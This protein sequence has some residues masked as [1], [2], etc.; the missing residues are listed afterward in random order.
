MIVLRIKFKHDRHK[1]FYNFI[2][3][4]TCLKRP[5]II[6][7]LNKGVEPDHKE[8]PGIEMNRINAFLFVPIHQILLSSWSHYNCRKWF[9]QLKQYISDNDLG[10]YPFCFNNTGF[11]A[12]V[13]PA[14]ALWWR[15]LTNSAGA[16]AR[17]HYDWQAD[18]Q[19]SPLLFL[20]SKLRKLNLQSLC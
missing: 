12:T 5:V 2:C 16:G 15:M 4:Q 8:C 11:G 18:L 1:I 14:V 7:F 10:I 19:P 6:I 20:S 3:H 9:A 17:S 13:F